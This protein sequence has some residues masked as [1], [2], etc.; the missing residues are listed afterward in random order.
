M[1]LGTDGYAPIEQY[2]GKTEPGSDIYAL[3]ATLYH[4]L[5]HK[6]PTAAPT[7][8]ADAASFLP[9]RQLNPALSGAVEAVILRAMEI[10]LARR[11]ADAS[12]MKA[13]L[14]GIGRRSSTTLVAPGGIAKR[15][16][17]HTLKSATPY[18]LPTPAL[19]V[20]ASRSFSVSAGQDTVTLRLDAAL[21]PLADEPILRVYPEHPIRFG[22]VNPRVPYQRQ[23]IIENEGD[24]PLQATITSNNPAV[25]LDVE[26]AQRHRARVTVW[27]K[28]FALDARHYESV[29]DI[30][31][32]GGDER[33]PVWFT[34]ARSD[35]ATSRSLTPVGQDR[36]VAPLSA[37]RLVAIGLGIAWLLSQLI[38]QIGHMGGPHM[39][40]P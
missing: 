34:V 39:F 27:L 18:P 33:L 10:H 7:R 16:A 15:S 6:V 37:G 30:T 12:E 14:E 32:N 2:S 29:I 13:A 19:P 36:R 9:P 23:F 22:L 21:A 4:L 24:E 26:P 31:S 28:P 3:G 40:H 5:T 38:A 1:C 25:L 20:P 35:A 8:V 11:Y 17:S